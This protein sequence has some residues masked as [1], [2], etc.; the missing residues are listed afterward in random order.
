[1]L[2]HERRPF[3]PTWPETAVPAHLPWRRPFLPHL[4]RDCP[5]CPPGLE[6]AVPAHLA[7]DC[8]TWPGDWPPAPPGQRRPFLPT[9]PGDWPETAPPGQRLPQPARQKKKTWR[10]SRSFFCL[11]NGRFFIPSP[12]DHILRYIRQCSMPDHKTVSPEL[13]IVDA[14]NN[15]PHWPDIKNTGSFSTIDIFQERERE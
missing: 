11:G 7:R 13:H 12:P 5:I 3:L 15:P 8:P 9:C 10:L 1:M 6:T 2:T 14:V 4:A